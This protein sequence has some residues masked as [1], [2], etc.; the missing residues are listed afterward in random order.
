MSP[1]DRRDV[2]QEVM[3]QLWK[4][5]HARDMSS[6][7]DFWGFVEIVAA[8]RCIDWL[9]TQREHAPL[10]PGFRTAGNPLS[11]ALAN[12]RGRLASAAIAQLNEPCQRLIHLRVVENC[13]YR[14]IS[15]ILETSESAL[16][17]RMHR[18]IQKAGEILRNLKNA[19]ILSTPNTQGEQ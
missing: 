1:E 7:L 8:R 15:Q 4:A 18:C 12:E 10:N 16:R 14:E 9:R 2:E 5:V 6:E 11:F 3:T 13:S 17:V 19:E